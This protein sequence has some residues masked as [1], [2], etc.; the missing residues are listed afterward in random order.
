MPPLTPPWPERYWWQFAPPPHWLFYHCEVLISPSTTNESY[1]MFISPVYIHTVW[2]SVDLIGFGS[3]GGSDS[4]V[5]FI[6]Y[7]L[8][9]SPFWESGWLFS[10]DT[11]HWSHLV[12]WSLEWQHFL[13]FIPPLP[14]KWVWLWI[15]PCPIKS[16]QREVTCWRLKCYATL[17]V[18]S[19][20]NQCSI[21]PL[22]GVS[23]WT[24]FQAL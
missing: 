8:L 24:D 17:N 12:N 11:S 18:T 9:P 15:K 14:P 20:H 16:S 4:N 21:T 3:T 6:L 7:S 13:P 2:C 1:A 22:C 19:T 10:W 5:V 23:I